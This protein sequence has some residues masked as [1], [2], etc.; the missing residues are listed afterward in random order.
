[1]SRRTGSTQVRTF[2]RIIA[3]AERLE[4]LQTADRRGQ[5]CV[6][7]NVMRRTGNTRMGAPARPRPEK[8]SL[9]AFRTLLMSPTSVP[10]RGL[11]PTDIEHPFALSSPIAQG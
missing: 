8:S 1:M 4:R 9:V 7:A 5:L 10:P 3:H 2:E 6:Q 11:P